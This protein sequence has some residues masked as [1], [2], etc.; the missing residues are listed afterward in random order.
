M[1]STSQRH[2]LSPELAL[3]DERVALDARASLLDP[4]D[5]L[6]R[7]LVE[8]GT[9]AREVAA[10]RKR[11]IELSDVAPPE[12]RRTSRLPKLVGAF[13]TWAVVI[14]LLAESRIYAMF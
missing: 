13:A 8:A 1:E 2:H 14:V 7:I 11:I 12:Y 9:S 6:D 10:A 3:V 4:D 5:T